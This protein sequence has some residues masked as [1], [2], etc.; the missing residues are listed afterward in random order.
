V[1]NQ[2]FQLGSAI[3]LQFHLELTEAILRDWSRELE[4]AD[5]EKILRDSPQ[6]LA[7]SNRLCRL[8]ADEFTRH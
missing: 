1:K 6:Y 3:G 5:Q 4:R 8:V 2:A 7:E